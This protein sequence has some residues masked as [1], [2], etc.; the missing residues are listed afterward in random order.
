MRIRWIEVW[1]EKIVMAGDVCAR[2]SLRTSLKDV[3]TW[4]VLQTSKFS[5]S[6]ARERNAA[7]GHA[8]KTGRWLR[9]YASN[10]QECLQGYLHGLADFQDSSAGSL[11]RYLRFRCTR[12]DQILG[13]CQWR[14]CQGEIAGV[15]VSSPPKAGARV[16]QEARLRTSARSWR[17]LRTS[18]GLLWCPRRLDVSK[19]R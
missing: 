8:R 2:G 10:H 14:H 1:N 19:K 17:V 13:R 11:G 7:D 18:W 4:V 15:Q 16:L 5:G 12:P 6:Q 9:R 3:R